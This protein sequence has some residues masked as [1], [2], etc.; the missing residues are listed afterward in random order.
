V[1]A[2]FVIFLRSFAPFAC[3]L[4]RVLAASA[5]FGG[6]F[7]ESFEREVAADVG[8]RQRDLPLLHLWFY[9]FFWLVAPERLVSA[10]ASRPFGRRVIRSR[11]MRFR[12]RIPRRRSAGLRGRSGRLRSTRRLRG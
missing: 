11:A 8:A 12:R 2:H 7:H 1:L 4:L 5:F 6:G 3:F 9:R 10:L